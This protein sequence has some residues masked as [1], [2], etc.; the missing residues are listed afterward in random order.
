MTVASVLRAEGSGRFRI[1]GAITIESA[2][3]VLESGAALLASAGV[4]AV[5]VDLSGLTDFDSA[6]LGVMFEWTRRTAAGGPRIRYDNLPPK[7]ATLARL[8]GVDV[9][10]AAPAQA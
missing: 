9:L 4:D 5:E 7:L 2:P 8:Y 10:L 6:V 3:A 1:D